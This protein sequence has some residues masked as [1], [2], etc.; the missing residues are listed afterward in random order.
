MQKVYL[1]TAVLS[2]AGLVST[3]LS[4]Q[5]KPGHFIASV[6]DG[7]NMTG[8]LFT[9][10]PSTRSA[11]KLKFNSAI[12]TNCVLMLSSSF[13]WIGTATSPGDI[14]QI[15]ITGTNVTTKKLNTSPI[16][17]S[18]IS[19]IVR[20]GGTLYF[21]NNSANGVH[22]GVWS[23]PMGGGAPKLI[24]DA[25]KLSPN[26]PA[27]RLANAL[28]GDPRTGKLYVAFWV[29]G[30]IIVIDTTAVA[31][32]GTLLM[33]IDSKVSPTNFFPIH[34]QMDSKG[35]LVVGG[36]QGD[37]AIIDVKN[38]KVLQHFDPKTADGASWWSSTKN[39]MAFNADTGDWTFGSRDA[40]IDPVA[41]IGTKHMA[42]RQIILIKPPFNATPNDPD[43]LSVNGLH[44][45]PAGGTTDSYLPYGEG[46]TNAAA[47]NFFPTS[48]GGIVTKGSQSFS[49]L[50][51]GVPPRSFGILIFG[52]TKATIPIGSCTLR[53]IPLL[54]LA[55]VATAS[56]PGRNTFA[57]TFRAQ[58]G[59]LKL[60]NQKMTL[61][62]QW[63]VIWLV[64]QQLNLIFSDA[65]TLRLQ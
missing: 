11:T 39:S 53:T 32:K 52:L 50:L 51:D 47:G 48:G 33:T 1:F 2:F 59:P 27:G 31:I 7:R 65:R 46:C 63:G 61:H 24:W 45:I 12:R 22:S 36:L 14:Y 43:N 9:V 18:N 41:A 15:V 4:A 40:A 3:G 6:A 55:A 42:R 16:T 19:Q 64:S 29:R 60:P 57:G 54:T 10:D 37:V 49:F 21:T 13:G 44:F 23:M 8:L 17:G 30:E 58:I 35:N 56:D 62:T 20:F 26:L 34:A 28:A 25:S 38:K 5:I